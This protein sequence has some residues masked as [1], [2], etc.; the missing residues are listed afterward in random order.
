MQRMLVHTVL[1]IRLAHMD[2]SYSKYKHKERNK[3]TVLQKEAANK[4]RILLLVKELLF[5]IDFTT[6]SLHF[7]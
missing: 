4:D 6:Q 1:Y 2:G 7:S 3:N 5:G